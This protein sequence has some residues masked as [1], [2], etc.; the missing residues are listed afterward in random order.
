MEILDAIRRDNE[1]VKDF[2]TRFNEESLNIGSISADML[3]GAFHKNVRS[4]ALIRCLIGKDG[5]PKACD[6]IVS[7]AKLFAKTK[8]TLGSESP[9]QKTKIELSN[10]RINKPA[11][12]LIWY[13]L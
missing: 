12:G 2:I 13:R 11:R 5:M 3:R 8:I 7:A 10:L 1:F 9:K 6:E 4:D